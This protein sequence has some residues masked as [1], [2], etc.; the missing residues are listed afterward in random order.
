[1]FSER[2]QS[3]QNAEITT[4][5]EDSSKIENTGNTIIIVLIIAVGL[6]VLFLMM[7]TVKERTKEIGLMKAIGFK[8]NSIMAQ[9]ILEGTVIGIFGGIIGI[10]LGFIAGPAISEALLPSSEVFTTSTPSITLILLALCLTAILGA[11]G[12]M[13]PAW[14]ASKKSPMEAMRNE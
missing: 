12:T 4:L 3:A 8:G 2:R 1:M 14:Q 11:V 7:Y 5:Q 9:I 13:Y 10:V 6:I